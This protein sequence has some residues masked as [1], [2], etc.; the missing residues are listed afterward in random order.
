MREVRHVVIP[1]ARRAEFVVS[2]GEAPA[3]LRTS[4]YDSG[5]QGDRNPGADLATLVDDGGGKPGGRRLPQ[6]DPYAPN[7]RGV[8]FY[9]LA[10]PAPSV[11][12]VVRLEEKVD[13]TDFASM[14]LHTIPAINPCLL[15]GQAR[16]S[17]GRS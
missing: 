15:R 5:P 2:G 8:D 9:L 17:A 16:L 11:A 7:A 12:R 14:V 1:P 13:G 4:A 10:L 3:V 6:S